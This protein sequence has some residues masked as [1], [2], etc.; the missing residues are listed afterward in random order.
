[1]TALT[2]S[3]AASAEGPFL[4]WVLT[5]GFAAGLGGGAGLVLGAAL[6]FAAVAGF[7]F[8]AGGFLSAI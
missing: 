8:G 5:E 2:L 3:M 4:G 1:M 6:A 7:F